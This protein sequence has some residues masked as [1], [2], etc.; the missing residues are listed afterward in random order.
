MTTLKFWII[1][2]SIFILAFGL[3]VWQLGQV[4][5]GMHQ[6]EAWFAYNAFLL[7]NSG[8]NIYGERWPLTVDMWG[9][10][11]SSFHSFAI[12]PFI[13][14]FG[15][16]TAAFRLTFVAI[17]LLCLVLAG[18]LIYRWTNSKWLVLL[19]A[20]FF[21]T[22][23]WNII[24]SRASSSVILDSLITLITLTFFA[25]GLRWLA[26]SK[27]PSWW[28]I[29]GWAAITYALTVFNYFTYFTSRLTLPL[30]LV[31]VLLIQWHQL[32]L[33]KKLLSVSGLII[34]AY[35]IFPFLVM[36]NTPFALGRYKETAVI[37]SSAV[38]NQIFLDISRSGQAGVPAP[39]TRL[40]YN[41]VTENARAFL[42]QYSSFFSPSVLLFQ[43]APPIRYFVPQAGV[44][45]IIEYLGLIWAIAAVVLMTE[46]R[47]DRWRV[48]TLSLLI[49]TGVALIPTAL[50]VD[51]FPN[52]QRGVYATPFWQMAAALG[53]GFVFIQLGQRFEKK[54]FWQRLVRGGLGLVVIGGIVV[55]VVLFMM[56]Y[57]G[58]SRY[59]NTLYRS[60]AGEELGKW[61]NAQAHDAK[62]IMDHDE[63]N[64]I[65]AYLFAEENAKQMGLESSEKHILKAQQFRI[66]NRLFIRELCRNRNL[67]QLLATEQP[68]YIIV[69]KYPE[70][71]VCVFPKEYVP[72]QDIHYD[73]GILG[74]QVYKYTPVAAE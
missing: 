8:E 71:D 33:S 30:F 61:I 29:G 49:M 11:V 16:S 9:D 73:D 41:K 43:T 35:A 26:K 28:M 53:W 12:V 4:P 32:K 42:V 22:S 72:V 59:A 48:V 15:T 51:D 69:K 6:D 45:N 50:T 67:D 24:M 1:G 37:N 46:P 60:R 18:W 57:I 39:I 63:A 31:A 27:H 38:Q 56:S 66:G 58:H 54:V 70:Y 14:F 40:F 64:F 55:S 34:V 68:E 62:I 65:Y 25:E 36:L 7:K 44:I 5:A 52:F 19:F 20:L 2:L 21:A 17:S 23:Q 74:Y 13:T 47:H 3:R 10:H